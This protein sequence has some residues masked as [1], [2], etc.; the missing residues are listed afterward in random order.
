MFSKVEL[1]K[2]VRPTKLVG[3]TTNLLVH[4]YYFISKFF[5]NY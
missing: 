5:L 1:V 4:I 3:K 2:I